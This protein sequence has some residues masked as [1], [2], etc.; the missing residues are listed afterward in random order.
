MPK[1]YRAA[2]AAV[3]LL[4]VPAGA[5]AADAVQIETEAAF[6]KAMV[7]KTASTQGGSFAFHADGRITGAWKGRPVD[8]IWNWVGKTF[9][10]TVS[11]GGKAR[12][13][14]CQTIHL[15]GNT[16]V[17]TRNEGKGRSL[18]YTIGN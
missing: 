14:D 16:I 8:G 18:E 17:F 4:A 15:K 6:R 11:I 10:R 5:I 9:C 7:G 12:P 3:L 13:Y 1:T 2:L